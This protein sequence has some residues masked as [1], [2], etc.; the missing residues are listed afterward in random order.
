[1]KT[2]KKITLLLLIF[3]VTALKAQSSD[4][5][6]GFSS[7]IQFSLVKNYEVS[8]V[9]GIKGVGAKD[10][11]LETNNSHAYS[12][13]YIFSYF[14]IPRMWSIGVGFGLER[15]NEPDFNITPL[16][17]DTR[18]FLWE[19][20]NSPYMYVNFGGLVKLSSAF[21]KGLTAKIGWGYKFFTS[22]K[23]CLNADLGMDAKGIA[24]S[25]G[26]IGHSNNT[27]YVKGVVLTVGATLF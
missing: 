27:L 8:N 11:K 17:L 3:V 7:I 1:M 13:N 20:K 10:H 9:V 26:F 2:I 15:Y 21:E 5:N 22:D 24:L 16:Y 4:R 6:E 19:I 14:V 18:I 25:S 12:L 23:I